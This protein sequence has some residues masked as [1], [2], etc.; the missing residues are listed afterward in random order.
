MGNL[1]ELDSGVTC[2][3][4]DTEYIRYKDYWVD[5]RSDVIQLNTVRAAML[6][7]CFVLPFG[8]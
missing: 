6:T 2:V 7:F 5:R 1:S 4:I 8:G 3:E